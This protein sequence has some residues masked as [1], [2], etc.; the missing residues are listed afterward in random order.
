M[1]SNKMSEN[2]NI[3][4]MPSEAGPIMQQHEDGA[5]NVKGR[6][7]E[8]RIIFYSGPAKLGLLKPCVSRGWQSGCRH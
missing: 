7:T 6:E 8:N 5:E 3:G 1:M 4:S 2:M